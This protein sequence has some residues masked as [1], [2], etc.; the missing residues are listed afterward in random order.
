MAFTYGLMA[1]LK[2]I[3]GSWEKKKRLKT[4]ILG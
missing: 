2:K 4:N 1:P 3:Y